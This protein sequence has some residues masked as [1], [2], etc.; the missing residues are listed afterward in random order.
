MKISCWKCEPGFKVRS[1]ADVEHLIDDLL[2]KGEHVVRV[3]EHKAINIIKT[4]DKII[5][6]V[7]LGDL[8]DP[9]NPLFEFNEREEIIDELWCSRKALNAKFCS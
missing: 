9:F 4:S 1:K 8:N 3:N 7:K 2:G 5:I 6:E